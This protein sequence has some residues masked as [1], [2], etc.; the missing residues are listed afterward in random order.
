LNLVYYIYKV[1]KH[2]RKGSNE[3]YHDN[4][5]VVSDCNRT[6]YKT[7]EFAQDSSSAIEEIKALL[8]KLPIR[9][10]IIHIKKK[11]KTTNHPSKPTLLLT[12]SN[13]MMKEQSN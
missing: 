3:I 5:K 2:I 10:K 13:N 8:R 4:L 7:T 11:K 12:S 1:A 9:V 6:K